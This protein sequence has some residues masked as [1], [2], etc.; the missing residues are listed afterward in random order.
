M[1]ITNTS[2]DVTYDFVLK[3]GKVS[4]DGVPETVSVAPGETVSVDVAE[5]SKSKLNALIAFGNL[6]A[7]DKD[8]EKAMA[9]VATA[10]DGTSVVY[11][12]PVR[13]KK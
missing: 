10:D 1:K 12:E 2:R 8:T 7:S 4:K 5:G 13:R 6:R 9:S 3:D 11:P